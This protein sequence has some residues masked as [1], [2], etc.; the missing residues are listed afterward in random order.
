ML[1]RGAA[2]G[3]RIQTHP[4]EPTSCAHYL[5]NVILE[6]CSQP[7][8]PLKFEAGLVHDDFVQRPRGYQSSH[9]LGFY[10][11]LGQKQK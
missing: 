7:T 9:S 6:M 2:Q 4:V 3:H 1:Q 11:I 8:C 5:N 10:K